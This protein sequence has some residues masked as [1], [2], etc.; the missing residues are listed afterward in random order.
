MYHQIVPSCYFKSLTQPISTQWC[1]IF[2]N[3]NTQDPSVVINSCPSTTSQ[4]TNTVSAPSNFCNIQLSTLFWHP[5]V[6]PH[7]VSTIS[8]VT[9]GLDCIPLDGC[10]FSKHLFQLSWLPRSSLM[11]LP[12]HRYSVEEQ[13][14]FPVDRIVSWPI[15]NEKQLIPI[16]LTDINTAETIL[17]FAI[18]PNWR[19]C[20]NSSL[21]NRIIYYSIHNWNRLYTLNLYWRR[22]V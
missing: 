13:Y 14:K 9:S 12:Y 20:N 10:R 15:Y 7:S 2:R 6:G 19:W 21:C 18:D 4:L 5:H 11:D 16:C 1:H 3:R 8:L 17:I 22:N